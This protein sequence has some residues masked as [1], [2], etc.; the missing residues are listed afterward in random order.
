MALGGDRSC[1]GLVTIWETPLFSRRY[2]K[3][4][5]SSEWKICIRGSNLTGFVASKHSVAGRAT[6]ILWICERSQLIQRKC[7]PG[8]LSITTICK[9]TCC[10]F[11][12]TVKFTRFQMIGRP[13]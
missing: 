8:I 5:I 9:R 12:T 7:R 6:L 2:P 13:T 3:D 1:L 4:S 10:T 11:Q